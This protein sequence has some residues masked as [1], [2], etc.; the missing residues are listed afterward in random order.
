[1]AHLSV[2]VPLLQQWQVMALITD[3]TVKIAV[4]ISS[5]SKSYRDPLWSLN[6]HWWFYACMW[7]QKL[8]HPWNPALFLQC[9]YIAKERING[10]CLFDKKIYIS[11]CLCGISGP[12][13]RLLFLWI[14]WSLLSVYMHVRQWNLH[15]ISQ[16]RFPDSDNSGPWL[17]KVC[18]HNHLYFFIGKAC[19]RVI[20]QENNSDRALSLLNS[21]V[22]AC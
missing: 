18:Q 13:V 22:C 14:A 10:V 21:T 16:A 17:S 3:L 5:F 9:V 19:N 8:H 20:M 4:F 7:P 15:A 6:S 1:M 2:R 12:N 11:R